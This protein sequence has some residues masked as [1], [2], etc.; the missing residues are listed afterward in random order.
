MISK[1]KL[2]VVNEIIF[3]LAMIINVDQD[4]M[5]QVLDSTN[6][7]KALLKKNC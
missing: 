2:E 5:K 3:N 4:I 1:L 7:I 6:M